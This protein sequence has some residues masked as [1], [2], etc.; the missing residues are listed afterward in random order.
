MQP[1]QMFGSMTRDC[2]PWG[3]LCSLRR[4][5]A[6]SSV[7]QHTTHQNP[8]RSNSQGTLSQYMSYIGMVQLTV[9]WP[10]GRERDMAVPTT[11]VTPARHEATAKKKVNCLE[12]PSS[13]SPANASK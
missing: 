2:P 7:A 3:W 9:R 5:V 1:P 12:Q 4:S 11:G 13:V 8:F 6:F 10:E